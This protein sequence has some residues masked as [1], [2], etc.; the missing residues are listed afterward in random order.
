LHP[1]FFL[2][3][4]FLTAFIGC[5]LLACIAGPLPLPAQIFKLE[6]DQV[7][8]DDSRLPWELLADEVAYD[9]Q[10]DH[11][12]ARGNV[13]ISRGD[14][15]LTAD[16][17]HYDHKAQRAFARG[18]VVLTV[19]QDILSGSD[20]EIDLENQRGFVENAY[21]FLKENNFHI[22]AEKIEKTGIKTY[23][24]D[25]ATLTT[26]DGPKPS[27]KISARNV[28][29][30]EDGAGTARHA[31]IRAR[32]VPVLYTPF[33]YYPARKNRQSGFLMPEFGE[34]QRKGYQYSQPFYWA[35]SD[36]TDAT[37]YAHY[38]SNRGIKPGA[39]FRYFLSERSKGAFMLDGLHDDKTDDGGQSSFDYGFRDD[40]QQVLR[41]NNS[42][43]WFRMSHHQPVPLGFSAKWDLDIVRDQDYLRAFRDGYMGYEDTNDYFRKAFNR[44]LDDYNDPIRTNRL[45]L[46]RLWPKFSLNFEPRW[47][48]DTRRN[49]NTSN[50]LQQLPL[51]SFDG[52]KQ[53][54]MTSP[55]YFDLASQYNY[56]W[57][58]TGSRG[59]RL[60]LQPRLYLPFRVQNYLTIEPSAGYR[61]TLYRLDKNNFEDQ[62]DADRWSHRELFDTRLEIFSEIEK[63]YN[64]EG[65]LFEK[66]KHRIRPQITHDIISNSSQEDL[67]RFDTIDRIDE[68]NKITY[69]L[70]NT[71]T[72]K[73]KIAA[74][75]KLSP[76]L[77]IERGGLRQSTADFLYNDLLRLEVMHSYDFEKSRQPFAPLFARLD[78]FPGKYVWIDADA[79]YSVY[80]NKFLSH[81][82]R[83]SLSDNRGDELYVDYR[84]E[85]KSKETEV[86]EDIQSIYGKIKVQLIDSLSVN[87]ENQ[88]NFETQQRIKTGAGFTYTSQCWSFDF[89]YFNEPNDWR[90]GFKIEL[91]GLGEIGN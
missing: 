18:N 19:G 44:Q 13:Q 80:D 59:Q 65:Q 33:F 10:L 56:F 14:I 41:T 73:S 64:L 1:I 23:Q 4:R 47:N 5:L 37:F 6:P 72:S 75:E 66:I 51:L 48:D 8:K 25:N 86:E 55:V 20:M 31:V 53:K 61:Q 26:C 36:S 35:I 68:T 84:Y 29:I 46:N 42:R 57:R 30:K 78:V 50:T 39:E 88:Y 16:Y 81:N 76:K 52:A 34:S 91:I 32:N 83:G 28:K 3:R 54:I 63:A 27:W 58:D 38:M 21:L 77:P 22:T 49:I 12:V 40:G 89:K 17:I 74:A 82:I 79:S 7:L 87:A 71:L 2:K 62:P 24:I 45:N 70:I 69:S 60:D 85:Q 9:Q 43:Y 90:V 67:P 11:Y 15:R